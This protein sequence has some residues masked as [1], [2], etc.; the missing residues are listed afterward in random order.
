[1]DWSDSERSGIVKALGSDLASTLL[2]GCAVHWA[3]SYQR[4]AARISS[5]S[6]TEIKLK[7]RET[8]EHI[9][10]AIPN[11]ANENQMQKCFNALN[12]SKVLLSHLLQLWCQ[13]LQKIICQQQ[14]LA[15]IG[16]LPKHGWT[17]GQGY[18]T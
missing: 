12:G 11:L 7:V 1:M 4:V 15:P 5:K 13:S 10:Q 2:R 9:A 14:R 17:G 18:T 6:S 16:L 3:R 8:F